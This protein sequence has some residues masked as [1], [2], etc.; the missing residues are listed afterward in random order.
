MEFMDCP[1]CGLTATE[2][3]L[4]LG[5]LGKTEHYRCYCCGIQWIEQE[6]D[7]DECTAK[8]N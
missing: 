6:E 2:D 4:L 5:T 7:D 8:S 3:E 1:G